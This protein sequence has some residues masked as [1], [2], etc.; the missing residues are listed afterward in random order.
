MDW[1]SLRYEIL[2][3]RNILSITLKINTKELYHIESKNRYP[4]HLYMIVNIFLETTEELKTTVP[5]LQLSLVW[6][7][8]H[9][10]KSL[11]YLF[12]PSYGDFLS[13]CV[14]KK[15]FIVITCIGI[16]GGVL[17]AGIFHLL[18]TARCSTGL[19][20]SDLEQIDHRGW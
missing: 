6:H 3:S 5:S 17:I 15:V 7:V 12:L 9:C 2:Y 10:K 16:M 8:L 18:R 19:N 20:G 1:A 13:G 4:L 11:Y 14:I